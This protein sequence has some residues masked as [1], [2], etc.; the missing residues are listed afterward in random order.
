MRKK[1]FKRITSIIAA[2][3]IVCGSNATTRICNGREAVC[4]WE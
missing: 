4:S 1:L 3:V 2:F